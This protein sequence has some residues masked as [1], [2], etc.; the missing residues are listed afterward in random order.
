MTEP[1]F[2]VLRTYAPAHALTYLG[3]VL[4]MFATNWLTVTIPV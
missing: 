1:L 4:A 2:R 3:G